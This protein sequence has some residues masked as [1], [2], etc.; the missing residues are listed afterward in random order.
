M[1]II[2]WNCRGLGNPRTVREVRNIARQ[3]VSKILFLYKTKCRSSIV[4]RLKSKINFFGISVDANGRSGGLAFLW[5]K[6]INV[7]ILSFSHQYID[8]VVRVNPETQSWRITSVYGD[9][10]EIL[11]PNEFEGSGP[12]PQWQ[13]DQFRD[14]LAHSDLSDLGFDGYRNTWFRNTSSPLAAKARLDRACDNP[15]WCLMFPWSS[16]QHLFSHVFDH[17]PIMRKWNSSKDISQNL[18]DHKLG[19]MHWS[20]ASFGNVKMEME[21]LKERID[22]LQQGPISDA[23]KAE[24]GNLMQKLDE[25]LDIE[26][27]KWKQWAKQH[28]YKFGDRNTSFFHAYASNRRETNTIRG[29]YNSDGSW[30]ENLKDIEAIILDHFCKIFAHSNQLERDLQIVL[31]RIRAKVTLEMNKRHLKTFTTKKEFSRCGKL[32]GI[33][34]NAQAPSISHLLFA[35]DTFLFG[36]ASLEETANFQQVIQLYERASGQCVNFDKSAITFS[37]NAAQ[38]VRTAI[39]QLL[40]MSIVELH[41]KYLGLPLVIDF[42]HAWLGYRPSFIWRGILEGRKTLN[43]GCRLQ[44]GSDLIHQDLRNW[45]TALID[46]IF[47]EEEASLIKSLPLSK[48]LTKDRWLWHYT[49]NGKFSVRSAYHA[50]MDSDILDVGQ[51]AQASSS[52]GNDVVWKKIWSLDIPNK[53]KHFLWRICHNSLPT[54][55]NLQKQR[56]P[57]EN[58]CSVCNG[59]S[60]DLSHIL[61]EC[62]V[63]VQIRA[64]SFLARKIRACCQSFADAWVKKILGTLPPK[65]CEDFAVLSYEICGNRN[66]TFFNSTIWDPLTLV[67]YTLNSQAAF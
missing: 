37:T 50:I 45:N 62:P 63:S 43:I 24:A 52:S 8:A 51:T 18:N 23:S 11:D 38:D 3:K 25:L 13:I 35:D 19:L 16:V 53:K 4:E 64:L 59:P 15:A 66:N 55:D 48:Y 21:Q 49:K 26:D 41:E 28:W 33:T 6:D 12:R 40:H 31:E 65:D 27:V 34:I 32:K 5:A 30:Y 44:V 1:N 57:V 2:R 67:S 17:R 7:S 58:K 22:I 42:L 61:F 47:W 9:F 20:K 39:S 60:G 36:R 14:A 46:E 29:L 56:I 10:N 54:S